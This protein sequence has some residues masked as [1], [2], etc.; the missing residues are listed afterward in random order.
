MG[1]KCYSFGLSHIIYFHPASTISSSSISFNL[2]NIINSAFA[3]EYVITSFT[4]RTLVNGKVDA[5]GSASI[6]KFS[7]PSTNITGLITK[8][9]SLYGGDSNINY[10]IEF[11]LNSD[12]PREGV[13]HLILPSVYKSLFELNSECVLTEDFPTGSYCSIINAHEVTIHP[14]GNLL[15]KDFG[16]EF[17]L[18]NITN[19]NMN[20]D[21]YSFTIKSL[22]NENIYNSKIISMNTF[23]SPS[24]S[25]FSVK[26]CT[27]LDIQ[28]TAYNAYYEGTYNITMICPSYIKEAS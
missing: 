13:I 18:T 4:V 23:S 16:Y 14:N 21:S 2:D 27:T 28:L 10:H 11:K 7:K 19:P 5:E 26:S 12:L 9:D 20:L 1:S 15:N 24:I 8:L 6:N 25:V 3:F 22:Y 17:I